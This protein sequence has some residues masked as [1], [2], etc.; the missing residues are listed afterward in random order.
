MTRPILT[1]DDYAMTDGV[2]RSIEALA[3]VR[4][5]SATSVMSTMPE[6]PAAAK[7]LAVLRDRLA[8]GLH[9]NLTLGAP[10]AAMPRLAPGGAFPPLPTLMRAA[11]LGHLAPD[12]IRAE[13]GRQFDAFERHLGFAPD[14]VDGHQH[15]HVLPIVRRALL[16]E[17]SQRYA[18]THPLLRDPSDKLAHL[19]SRGLA[20]AKGLT[21]TVLA[22]GFARQA[23]ARGM[24]AN[25]AF[26]G[27]SDFN[28]N[29][30]YAEEI[31]AA[32]H[33]HAQRSAGLAIIM[34]HPGYPDA[35]LAALDP[36]VDR[37]LQEHDALMRM[38]AL[39]DQIWHVDRTS[40]GAAVDWREMGQTA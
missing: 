12:E 17:L 7:R 23:R 27:F 16:A 19:R 39:S 14:H 5:L 11:F 36:V 35:A 15:V 2:S 6:W 9:L 34:C 13:I 28:T 1:A 26:T 4:R 8:I 38:D 18:S 20:G 25:T 3:H 29:C 32:L 37:R 24:V 31:T 10:L 21:V 22:S 40:D 30:S 33:R